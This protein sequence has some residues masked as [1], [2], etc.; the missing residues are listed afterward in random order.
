MTYL[1]RPQTLLL[2]LAIALLLG[3]SYAYVSYAMASSVTT[4]DRS[5]AD[6]HP[7]DYGLPYEDVMFSPRGDE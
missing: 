4:P 7:N 5:V 3:G 6:E 1:T 2:M